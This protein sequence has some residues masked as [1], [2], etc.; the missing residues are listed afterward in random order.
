MA[1][2]KAKSTKASKTKQ[3]PKTIEAAE[4]KLEAAIQ[5]RDKQPKNVWT[6]RLVSNVRNGRLNTWRNMMRVGWSKF[7]TSPASKDE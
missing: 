6:P 1:T 4:K 3:I 7:S 2:P 5:Y